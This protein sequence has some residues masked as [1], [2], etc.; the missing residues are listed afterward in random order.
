MKY[1][2]IL[3]L[4]L[5]S[6]EFGYCQTKNSN[7]ISSMKKTEKMTI[8]I[9]SDIM[10]P[11][12]YIGKR[13]LENALAKFEHQ[14][15]VELVW[16]S[17]QLDPN[18]PQQTSSLNPYEYLA[19]R[20]GISVQQS[21]ELHDYV[22]AMAKEVGLNYHYE[23]AKIVNSFDAHRLIQLAK[24]FKLGN[25]AEELLFKAYFIEGKDLGN[26]ETLKEIGKEIGISN[27]ELQNLF[28]K[29]AY[30]DEVIND[31]NQAIKLKITGVP[32]FLINKKYSIS[33]A[34]PSRQFLDVLHKAYKDW[35]K[36][37]N[38]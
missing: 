28:S 2:K 9:W 20:K 7:Q 5:F 32:Y 29:N 25:E 27:A 26:S 1:F 34:Q 30:H 31:F 19:E 16:H 6:L 21:K 12:C 24:H 23:K 4:L 35:E 36:S 8:D 11:F 17:F 10:C 18:L 15:N 33:G 22:I 3:I 14:N 38:Q 37:E 13:N